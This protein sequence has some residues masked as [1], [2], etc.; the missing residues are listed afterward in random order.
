[1]IDLHSHSLLSDGVLIPSELIRR[2]D[3]EGI[4]IL[5]ITDHVDPSNIEQVVPRTVEAC[6]SANAYWNIQA[7][8][9]AEITHAP[10]ELI[11]A[12]VKKCRELGAQLVVAHG[13]TIVEPVPEGTNRAAIDAGVDILAHPGLISS[14]EAKLAGAKGVFLELS[15]RKG[16]AYCNGH[17]A[18]LAKQMG[19]KLV[20]NSDAHAPGDFC[21]SDLA[22]KMI[23]GAGVGEV[24]KVFQNSKELVERLIR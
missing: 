10:I 2:A 11:P 23:Q 12:L 1:M 5:A 9:G 3:K 21:S 15:G 24:E 16:H 17:V 6:K 8:P 14:D 22:R 7:I 13:E 18:A 4:T 19:A 20:F